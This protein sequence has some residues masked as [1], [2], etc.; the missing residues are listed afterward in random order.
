M[1]IIAAIVQWLEY[2]VVAVGILVRFQIVAIMY[3][4][5][6]F[7]KFLFLFFNKGVNK[8]KIETFLENITQNFLLV[9]SNKKIYKNKERR[10]GAMI[11]SE[12]EKIFKILKTWNISQKYPKKNCLLKSKKQMINLQKKLLK[13]IV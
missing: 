11:F 2:H 12:T 3:F 10:L 6:K 4:G 5:T 9:K 1:S 8:K 7:E 13:K